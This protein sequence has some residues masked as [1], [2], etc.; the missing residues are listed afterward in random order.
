MN[1]IKKALHKLNEEQSKAVNAIE[2]PVFVLAGPGTGKTQI[3]TLRIVKI[4][5][6]TDSLPDAILAITFTEAGVISMRNRLKKFIGNQAL[7]VNIHTFHSFCTDLLKSR[8]DIFDDISDFEPI[9]DIE[10]NQIIQQILDNNEYDHIKPFNRKFHYL[11]EIINKIATLKKEN[12][13]PSS[14]GQLL[15][16]NDTQLENKDINKNLEL[17]DVYKK[18]Q[19]ILQE[20]KTYDFEDM[21]NFVLKK[22]EQNSEFLLS[23]QERYQYLLIDEFQDTNTS[24]AELVYKIASYWGEDANIFAVGDDDQSIYRFQGASTENVFDFNKL[25]PNANK[26]SLTKNYRSNQKILDLADGLISE[27]TNR[28]STNLLDI[29]KRQ[30]S[31][32]NS[33]ISVD[34]ACKYIQFRNSF[35]E[36]Y[37]VVEE[38][39]KLIHN[40]TPLNE[41]AI[42]YRNNSDPTEIVNL[43]EKNNI[44]Y[45]LKSSQSIFE[46]PAIAK[47][48]DLLSIIYN[49]RFGY[50]DIDL[51]T[52]LN[53]E[54]WEINSTAILKISRFASAN[55][56]DIYS[57]IYEYKGEKTEEI[58]KIKSII[59]S[60]NELCKKSVNYDFF[61]LVELVLHE[62][63]YLEHILKQ[64]NKLELLIKLNTFINYFRTYRA[65]LTFE[66][67]INAY[68]IVKDNKLKINTN[69]FDLD[70]KG[71]NLMTAHSSKGLEFEHV[72]IIKL[73]TKHWDHKTSKELIKLPKNILDTTLNKQE[74]KLIQLEESRRLLFVA[75]TR[76]KKTVQMLSS[77]VYVTNGELSEKLPSTFLSDF[78][79]NTYNSIKYPEL[80][81]EKIHKQELEHKFLDNIYI[82]E[83]ILLKKLFENYKISPSDLNKYLKCPY[84]F[85]LDKVIRPLQPY[86]RSLVIGNLIHKTLEILFVDLKKGIEQNKQSILSNFENLVEKSKIPDEEI[87]E[88]KKHGTYVLDRYLDQYLDEYN[89]IPKENILY[90]EKWYGNGWFSPILDGYVPLQ[91]KIDKIVK[92]ENNNTT[93]TDYKTGRPKTR[94]EILGNTKNST[95]DELRQLTFYKLMVEYVRN[96]NL[97][98]NKLELDFTGTQ[99][100]EPVKR[101]IELTEDQIQDTKKEIID[102]YNNIKNLNF[103]R[104]DE[105]KHCHTCKYKN[106]CWGTKVPSQVVEI[107]N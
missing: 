8:R 24:Q 49:L 106:H 84:L 78:E 100:K 60:L 98:V 57:A 12:V 68:Q 2:G 45:N 35:E 83:E 101:T 88:V 73:V 46:E 104:T 103:P 48:V 85:K 17:L 79:E 13:S 102:T 89:N 92:D 69:I 47:F 39:K 87:E 18:Y 40:G 99:T 30:V 51:F 14:Y 77:D 1:D 16:R 72:F 97:K 11:Y 5:Q 34:K 44:D 86:N 38:I 58:K 91:G 96:S 65:N 41:I 15:S 32:N 76:A 55:K 67:Y 71:I 105:T 74:E 61:Q 81:L 80:P 63:G 28:V 27:N 52:L 94:N 4:L 7:K 19:Q 66:E 43:L 3:L 93:I 56:L 37:Y 10:R 33:S 23:L 75:I 25:Y 9:S 36:N 70:K 107:D 64:K 62:T 59:N 22:L 20:Q 90:L 6:D 95:K 31:M 42:I 21:I 53:W 82:E 29:E 54:I 26:I 50:D